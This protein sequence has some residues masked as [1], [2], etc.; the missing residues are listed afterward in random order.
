MD[1]LHCS[2]HNWKNLL[3]LLSGVV[4]SYAAEVFCSF[5]R[6]RSFRKYAP[7]TNLRL[8]NSLYW[9]GKLKEMGHVGSRELEKTCSKWNQ[10]LLRLRAQ[11]SVH[12]ER[13]L[14]TGP[15]APL[16]L[17]PRKKYTHIR[18][19]IYEICMYKKNIILIVWCLWVSF[20]VK[21]NSKSKDGSE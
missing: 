20:N 17:F 8:F 5:F 12:R 4:F 18:K 6:S 2:I 11:S 21:P 14:T 10:W 9:I 16:L 1:C 19:P 15:T 13:I 7:L 3:H